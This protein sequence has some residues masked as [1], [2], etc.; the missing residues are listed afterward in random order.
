M[1]DIT[2]SG[3]EIENVSHDMHD[4]NNDYLSNTNPTHD[5]VGPWFFVT[6]KV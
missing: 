1:V 3:I 2:S 4:T 6:Y 5:K